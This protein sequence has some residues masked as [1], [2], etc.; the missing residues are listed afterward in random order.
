MIK[1][2][3]IDDKKNNL[4]AIKARLEDMFPDCEVLTAQSGINGIKIAK[5]KLPDVIL[6]DII[7]PD[8]N[9]FDVC[10]QL[11]SDK[12]VKH[13]PVIL[14][15]AIQT[16]IDSRIK[17]L[18]SGAD[19]FLTMPIT[20]PEFSAQ[21][22]AMLRIKKAEDIFRTQKKEL[23]KVVNKQ[24]KVLSDSEEKFHT[25]IE[26][27]IEGIAYADENEN[28]SFVNQALANIFGYSKEEMIGKDLKELTSPEMFRKVLDQTK[29]RKQK[30]SGRYELTIIRKNGEQR[31]ITVTATPTINNEGK[32]EGAFGIFHDITE[33]K[34]A[35]ELLYK[36]LQNQK[37][38]A[39]V[40][41]LFTKLEDFDKNINDTL[42]LIGEFTKVSRVYVFEDFNNGK[43]TKNTY[44][45]Y[46]KNIEPQ[47]DNLQEVP[48]KIIPSFKKLFIEKGMVFSTNILE[49]PQDLIDILKPQKIKSILI[50]PIYVKDQFFGFMGFDECEKHRIWDKSEI[51]LLKTITNIISTLFERKQ[52]EEEL[53]ES[54]EKFRAI[55]ES[56]I[57]S[58]FI[59]DIHLKYIHVNPAMEKLFGLPAS[60]LIGKT[61][62]KLFGEEAGKHITEIDKK[63]IKG[64]I[65][66]DEHEKTVRG[67]LHSFHTIKVPLKNSEGKIIGLCGIA[68][69]ITERKHAEEDLKIALEKAKES[70]RLKSA[71]LSTMSHEL[72]TPLN[73]IIGFSEILA[74]SELSVDEVKDFSS[75]ILTSGNDLLQIINDI[76]DISLI[77]ADEIK[78]SKEKFYINK[79]L[80]DIHNT[81]FNYDKIQNN[82]IDLIINNELEEGEDIIYTDETKFRQILNNLI[83]NA[84]K[85]THQG[86]IE[87]G[88]TVKKD[89]DIP[90]LQFYVKD[91]GIGIPEDKQSI[92]FERFRQA[93][94]SH[95]RKYGGIGLGL[96]IT[97]KLL[98]LLGGKIWVESEEGKGSTFFFT[99]PFDPDEKPISTDAKAEKI[100]YDWKDK[101]I[102]V[103]EDNTIVYQFI[104]LALKKTKAYLLWTK[105]GKDAISTFES[106][107]E[108][109]LV[110]M[111]IQLPDIS[112]YEVTKQL[113]KIN[114]DIPVIAQTAYAL[115]GDKEKSLEAGCDDYITKP[116]K[117][118]KLLSLIDKYLK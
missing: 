93:D 37:L 85:F 48:Y 89:N 67:E 95:T 74:N 65:L 19:A 5:E 68:R 77:E 103:V 50:L 92:I 13:I 43:Y 110:L 94:D 118:K 90:F 8:M 87:F 39:E 64:E 105:R 29:L 41:Y 10:K 76:I 71:F 15:T 101:T 42:R 58:I 27:I 96:A 116:I 3:T 20:A 24:T 82:Q 40:S 36:N 62:I 108:I 63:V 26:T 112:G 56:A 83:K 32:Y 30:E 4:T 31:I 86:T 49:L 33:Q 21:V 14:I 81:F 57:D 99:L 113:K 61:D 28:F 80:K 78:I 6:L 9:G 16:D 60:N 12:I 34:Q 46:N 73:G 114:K 53:R 23:E 51:E 52:G 45:W 11:K 59:K 109:D 2:L 54:E 117:P 88:Y 66:I 35:E 47:I 79:T 106:N 97:E 22:S 115:E 107:K 25:L 72:R 38:L 98:K 102:L 84:F 44:E 104:E 70:D 91:T 111:D 55:S 18:E 17:G 69:D 100:F 1:I 75:N 7:M